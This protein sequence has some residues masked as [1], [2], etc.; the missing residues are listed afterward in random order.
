MT[1]AKGRATRTTAI[2]LTRRPPASAAAGVAAPQETWPVPQPHPHPTEPVGAPGACP[3]AFLAF[4]GLG[5]NLGDVS[6]TLASAARAIGALPGTTLRAASSLYRT[7]PV[8][9]EG[10]DYLNAV[11]AVDCALAPGELMRSLL[12]I[13]VE[14]DRQRPFRHAPRTVDLDLLWFG[15]ATRRSAL[16][17]LP[18]PRMDQRAFVLD[19]LAE[20]LDGLAQGAQPAGQAP[21]PVLPS[22]EQREILARAQGI[23]RAW[24]FPLA[25]HDLV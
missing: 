8:D 24:A 16:L 21:L 13:E 11:L 5:G 2:R 18:H 12:R 17:L 14:H 25:I 3:P 10:P 7:R 1:R 20:V 23:S 15:G 6:A 22:L 9:A 4:I 19:P